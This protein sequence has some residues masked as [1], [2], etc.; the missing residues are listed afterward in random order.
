MADRLALRDLAEAYAA[1]VDHLDLDLFLSLWVDGAVLAVHRDGPDAPPTVERHAPADLPGVIEQLGRY[2]RRMH[3]VAN[4]RVEIEGDHATGEVYCE[5]HH[6]AG[7]GDFVMNIRYDDVY[8]RD[9]DRWRF[10]RRA[11]KTLWTS[12]RQ[13]DPFDP[14]PA[15]R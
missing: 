1:A 12:Q 7:D 5:A 15:R 11:V 8:R 2:D 9:G 3:I 4:Q 13:V 14:P 6:V 10:E